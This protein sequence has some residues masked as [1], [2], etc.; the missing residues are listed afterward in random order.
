MQEIEI[1]PYERVVYAQPEIRP[2]EGDA[3]C[4]QGFWDKNRSPNP[5]QTTRRRDNQQKKNLPNSGLYRLGRV[6][7]KESEKR[8]KYLDFEN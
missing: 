8:N 2:T 4:S 7:L 1:L 5:D 3:Q 6:K